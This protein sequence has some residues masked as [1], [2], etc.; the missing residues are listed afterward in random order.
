LCIQTQPKFIT[1]A[2]HCITHIPWLRAIQAITRASH[3]Y[4]LALSYQ[5]YFMLC[6]S[7]LSTYSNQANF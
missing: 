4:T 7:V 1:K 3:L 5:K 2:T 6:S